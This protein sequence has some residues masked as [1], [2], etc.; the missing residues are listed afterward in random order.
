MDDVR[1]TYHAYEN[2]FGG[3]T[4]PPLLKVTQLL[5]RLVVGANIGRLIK[6]RSL[7]T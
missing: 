1:T 6:F 4:P 2:S 7:A 3:G 5:S